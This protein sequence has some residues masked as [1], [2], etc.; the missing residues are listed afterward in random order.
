MIQS[1]Q[2]SEASIWLNI[3]NTSSQNTIYFTFMVAMY[4]V[5]PLIFWKPWAAVNL[6]KVLVSQTLSEP[7]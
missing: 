2:N 7:S 5:D 1:K 6:K 3:K 4:D